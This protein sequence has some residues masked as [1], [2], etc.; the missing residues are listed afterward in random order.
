MDLTKDPIPGL[1]RKI[2][3]PVTVGLL[4][5]SMYGI[6]DTF[7]AGKLSTE[8][9]AALSISSPAFFFF[10]T[11]AAGISNGANVLISNALGRKNTDEARATCLQS[12]SFAVTMALFL[13]MLAYLSAPALLKTLGATGEYLDMSLEYFNVMLIGLVFTI[14]TNVFFAALRAQGETKSYRNMLVLGCLLNC[15]LNPLFMFG[16]FGIPAM[17]VT[18]LALSTSTINLL[19]AIYLFHR[20]R[21]SEMW[22]GTFKMIPPP[23]KTWWKIAKQ[24]LPASFNMISMAFAW[25]IAT[26]FVG[27]FSNAGV[28]A[29][30]IAIRIE[31]FFMIPSW[32]LATAFVSMVG[33]N[34]GASNGRRIMEC[35]KYTTRINFLGAIAGGI[36]LFVAAEPLMRLFS[37]DE[38]VIPHGAN[39]LRVAAIVLMARVVHV[40]M[41]SLLQGLKRPVGIAWVAVFR[42]IIGPCVL[43]YLMAFKLGMEVDGVWWSWCI[44]AW[45][46]AVIL[47]AFAMHV[48][49]QMY[50]EAF[51]PQKP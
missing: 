12:I 51:E 40:M 23:D 31:T 24:G 14:L 25:Y 5:D 13:V 2:A 34:H 43:G 22:G 44:V 30:G 27:K 8:A 11:T 47:F 50:A 42:H 49:K 28:A 37:Q 15:M 6:V 16:G 18:G 38:Q 9:L 1:T 35:L 33:Q 45:T 36:I 10:I 46:S 21:R 17:G 3:L 29:Y 39:Y 48:F 7:F 41:V 4:F 20:L 32:A 19:S 26:L